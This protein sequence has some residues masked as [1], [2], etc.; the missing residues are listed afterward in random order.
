MAAARASNTK[1]KLG[2][3]TQ[4]GVPKS[5]GTKSILQT[6]GS[7][8]TT[9]KANLE[10]AIGDRVCGKL[11]WRTLKSKMSKILKVDIGS[12]E[13]ARCIAAELKHYK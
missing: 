7:L 12:H 9:T 6:L 1:L 2:Q 10:K 5:C 4:E 3:L 8:S 13:T 11:G